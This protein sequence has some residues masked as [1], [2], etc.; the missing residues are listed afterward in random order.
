MKALYIFI[1][2]MF[3]SF[4]SYAEALIDDGV[5]AYETAVCQNGEELSTGAGPYKIERNDLIIEGNTIRNEVKVKASGTTCEIFGE[6]EITYKEHT[7]FDES[8]NKI[9]TTKVADYE[10]LV[11]RNNGCTCFPL[12]RFCDFLIP[13]VEQTKHIAKITFDKK[14]I[15][16]EEGAE[17]EVNDLDKLQITTVLGYEITE[18]GELVLDADGN[19]K[20]VD[21]GYTDSR[22]KYCSKKGSDLPPTYKFKK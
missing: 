8:L 3:T 2:L 7:F 19:K 13:Q 15:K 21:T 16:N 4:F 14:V 17:V 10:I 11:P 6:G 1:F 18:E 20:E 22:R 12:N 5:Y 9:V